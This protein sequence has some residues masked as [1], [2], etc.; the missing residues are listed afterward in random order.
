MGRRGTVELRVRYGETDRMG[1][2]YHPNYL[3][4]CEIG[5]TELI[6]ELAMSYRE[7]EE[8]GILLAVAEATV[9]YKSPARYD[10]PIRVETWVAGVG[11]RMVTFE[12]AIRHVERGDELATART[13]LASIDRSGRVVSMPRELRNALARGMD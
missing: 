13:T 2:V 12:Y 8:S 5:R 7:V 1:V 9:R 11:S 10:D 4:W 6:R 3:I